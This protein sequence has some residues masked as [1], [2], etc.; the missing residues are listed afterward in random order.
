M[1]YGPVTHSGSMCTRVRKKKVGGV[2]AVLG[3]V[4]AEFPLQI[5]LIDQE[6]FR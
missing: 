5:H 6:V 1:K 4:T 3:G 2:T